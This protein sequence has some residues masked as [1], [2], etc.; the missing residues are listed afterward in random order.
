MP[1]S[2]HRSQSPIFSSPLRGTNCWMV[3]FLFAMLISTTMATKTTIM[4]IGQHKTIDFNCENQT[5]LFIR[6]IGAKVQFFR[7]RCQR[8]F[9]I[10]FGRCAGWLVVL[11]RCRLRFLYWQWKEWKCSTKFNSKQ[12]ILSVQIKRTLT[13]VS[14]EPVAPVLFGDFF[15]VVFTFRCCGFVADTFA[16]ATNDEPKATDDRGYFWKL[17]KNPQKS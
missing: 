15:G 11:F 16:F 10:A 2:L 3:H 4:T 14:F 9:A 6:L 7:H 17:K 8:W 5:H 12:L 1:E 13:I